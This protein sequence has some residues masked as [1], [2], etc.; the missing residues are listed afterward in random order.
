MQIRRYK[1]SDRNEIMNLFYDTVYQVNAKDYN[2]T[3]L[4]V[5]APSKLDESEWQETLS[6]NFTVVATE[7]NTIVGFGDIESGGYLN[8][9]FVH[10]D[11]QG[12][13]V[14][15]LICDSLEKA[16]KGRITTHASITA[17][18]FFLK[19][20]YRVLREQQVHRNGINLTN[21]IMVKDR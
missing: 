3:Q 18:D 17:K 20:G 5:W 4:N 7:G 12:R 14:A 21:Y 9:L 8:R 10:K 11:W 19:R 13:G 15:T 2:V 1:N 6:N 16:V